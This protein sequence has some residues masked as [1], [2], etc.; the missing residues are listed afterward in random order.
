MKNVKVAF[1]F[2]IIFFFLSCEKQALKEANLYK[3][4]KVK[5]LYKSLNYKNSSFTTQLNLC[6]KL[7]KESNLNTSEK[8]S[9]YDSFS[10][11]YSQQNKIDSAIF[12]T[13]KMLNLSNVKKE[14]NLLGQVYF[15]LGVYYRKDNLND[16]AYFYFSKSK[17]E[18]LTIN[19]SINTRKNLINLAIIESNFGNYSGS[20]YLLVE[21]LKYYIKKDKHN[22]D[23]TYNSLAINSKKRLLYEDAISY[24]KK[25]I[26]ISKNKSSIILYKSNLAVIY[27]D[28]R[29][30]SASI[31]ILE[32]LLN[33]SISNLKTRANVI[34]NLAYTKWLNNSKENVLIGLLQAEAI[35]KKENDQ[36]GLVAS[37]AHLSDYYKD[38]SESK[39]LN[40][41]IKSYQISKKQRSAVGQVQAIDKIVTLETPQKSIKYYKESIRLK[42][43]LK[44]V[45][46]KNQYKF[47]NIKYNYEVEEKQKEKFE[48]IAIK[49]K[50]IAEQENNHKKNISIIGVVLISGL[51]FFI[52]IRKQQHKKR[53]LQETYNTETRIAKKLHDELGNDIFNTLTKIQNTKF[54]TQ[55]I[56]NDLDKIYLQARSISHENASIETGTNFEN[57]FRSLMAS[58]NSDACKIMVKDLSSLDLNKLNK[59]KQVVFYRVFNELFVNMRKHSKATLV[60]L[61]CKNIEN[62][63]EVVYADNGVG[64]KD[65]KIIFKNGLKNM[66]TRTNT[67]NGSINF[68]NRI[69][70]GLKVIFTLKK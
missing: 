16:S 32:N 7:L 6:K 66:E 27:K 26:N 44:E 55:E 13:Q 23:Y 1:L 46:T 63:L 35:R 69:S 38:N 62:Y 28:L 8:Y 61:S 70:N 60:V 17:K 11:F 49:N 30:Y 9:I 43:S 42:D 20:D 34:D 47:A 2:F 59:E 41:A 33:D 64:F 22:I 36:Y 54:K 39:S 67:I 10:F 51:L 57:Y 4:S 52:Y 48:K 24:Y 45:E 58:Y 12:Y 19:D 37:Y 14:N 3:T 29:E 65:K 40:Y 53:I 56:I 21:S 18:F 31:S 68:E 5:E 15:K 25:A 50:L